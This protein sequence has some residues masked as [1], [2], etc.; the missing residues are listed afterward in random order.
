ME[1]LDGAIVSQIIFGQL[2]HF[3]VT[4][5]NDQIQKSHVR[6]M[7]YELD[8][9]KIIAEFFPRG[10]VFVDIGANIGNHSIYV[11][12]FL[13]PV[14]V[15]AFEPMPAAMA[16][17]RHNVALN[18]L[19]RLMDLSQLGVGLSESAARAVPVSSPNNLGGTHMRLT[20]DES[21]LRLMPGDEVLQ[22]RRI[23]FLKIDVEGMEM[24]VLRGLSATIARWRPTMFVEVDQLNAE[25]FSG[26]LRAHDYVVQRS[27]RRYA[28][29]ENH[30]I[31]PLEAVQIP[32]N[33]G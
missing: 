14:Q 9:L 5:E 16:I 10:G 28:R 29:N 4:N 25:N 13:H 7:F 20:D 15:I 22:H 32:A 23:D 18:G 3:F 24:R 31:M 26:W 2:V 1:R 12:K 30:L 21:G 6:G 33:C 19:Q 8:E 17:L 11:C 27:F